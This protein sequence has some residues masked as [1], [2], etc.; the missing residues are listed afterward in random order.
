MQ[1]HAP[2]HLNFVESNKIDKQN[3]IQ[4]NIKYQIQN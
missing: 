3:R 4:K 1:S 2:I